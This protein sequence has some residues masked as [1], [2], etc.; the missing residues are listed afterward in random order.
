MDKLHYTSITIKKII[1]DIDEQTD[2]VAV[3]TY[4][5]LK[6][7]IVS[8]KIIKYL[9]RYRQSFFMIYSVDFIPKPFSCAF[10][11]RLLSHGESY[12][13]D[14]NNRTIRITFSY[15][16]RLFVRMVN[17]W[18]S[19][20]KLLC[21]VS[22]DVNHY[23]E[24]IEKKREWQRHI[25]FTATPVYLRTDLVFGLRSGG[26]VGHIAGVLNSMEK[27]GGRPLFISSD[28][29]ISVKSHVNIHIITPDMLFTN[30]NEL[31]SFNFNYHLMNEA[32]Q[33][34]ADIDVSFI[35]Q[36]YSINNYCGIRLAQKYNIPFVLEY[37]GSEV[38]IA[39]NWGKPL[40]Y[41]ALSERIEQLNLRGADLAVVVSKPMKDELIARGVHEDRIL[42]N[43]NGVDPEIYSP[44]IDGLPI[45]KKFGLEGTT[46]VGFIGTFGKWHGAE[47]LAEAF[48]I[49]LDR[50][51]SLR[52]KVR[53]F[54][55]GDGLTMTQVKSELERYKIE[56]ACVL[57]GLV[58]QHDGPAY[59]AA[60]DI[61][62]APHVPNK[63]GTPF[64]GSP[65]KLF[66]YM[67]MGKAIVASNL[68]QIG[69]VLE[70]ER[71]AWMVVP[72]DRDS[73]MDGLKR[74]IDDEE[75]CRLLGMNARDEAVAKYSWEN[76]TKRI[77]E[78]LKSVIESDQQIR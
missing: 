75:L 62:V 58:P 1:S 49:M 70:H 76:H 30:I 21:R 8:G 22:D 26:S 78:K 25:D 31:P 3:F 73:L 44:H 50:Y 18:M 33:I 43:P 69:E 40:K 68:D 72:G 57:T 10:A 28:K 2:D 19:R 51:P 13:K 27:F 65:T 11:A 64:F 29:I 15:L 53:L 35:Y 46:V 34:L 14:E 67:A 74:L 9:F 23:S 32:T 5:E 24:L 60:C 12:F 63:D 45:R 6:K 54:M 17:E 4:D 66:E 38:W 41:E 36:R 61:L 52:K 77:F 48:G 55:I 39:R 20:K 47:L 7:L 42:V 37:N 71:T 16:F 56:E 59:L